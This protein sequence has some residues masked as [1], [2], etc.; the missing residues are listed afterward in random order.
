[1]ENFLHGHPGGV[2]EMRSLLYLLAALTA[3]SACGPPDARCPPKRVA[4]G[5]HE[6]GC[7]YSTRDSDPP[8]YRSVD[9]IVD[10]KAGTVVVEYERE[11]DGAWV[12]ET[13][14]IVGE[15]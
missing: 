11:S 9:A 2:V 10:R 7:Y 1:M 5:V 14:R 13:W 8:R 15:G 6:I 4:D 3:L 12:R